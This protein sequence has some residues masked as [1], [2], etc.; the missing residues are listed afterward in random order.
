MHLG[1]ALAFRVL[2]GIGGMNNGGID[3]SALTQRQAF[4]LQITVDDRE[5]C[6]HELMLLQQCRNFMI[7]VSSGIGALNVRRANWRMGVIS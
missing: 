2:S 3:D 1:I 7:V 6:R 5:D 4:F